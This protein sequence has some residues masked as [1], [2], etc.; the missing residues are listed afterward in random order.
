MTACLYNSLM[1]SMLMSVCLFRNTWLEMRVNLGWVFF[2]LTAILFMLQSV[3]KPLRR[4]CGTFTA[5]TLSLVISCLGLWLMLGYEGLKIIP[6]SIIREG[7]MMNRISFSAI[8]TA[9]IATAIIGLIL[10]FM[11]RENER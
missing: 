9:M 3:I 11:L 6:A 8:N 5:S 10:T 7:L 1:W 4:I 2:G